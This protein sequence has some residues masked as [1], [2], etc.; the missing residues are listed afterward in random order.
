MVV[1]ASGVAGLM[2]CSDGGEPSNPA[3]TGGAVGSS[4]PETGGASGGST[5]SA[6]TSGMSSGGSSTGGTNPGAGAGGASAGN[7]G[8]GGM[9]VAGMNPGGMSGGSGGG[10]DAGGSNAG[11]SGG[12]AAGDTNGGGAAGTAGT[13]AGAGGTAGTAGDGG[14]G[15]MVGGAGSGGGEGGIAG[16]GANAG[17]EDID[18]K[19]ENFT[20]IADWEKVLGFRITNLLGHLD[21]ALAVAQS[22][23]GT[24][25]VGTV[26]QHLP[27][28]AM[29]KRR[30]GFSPETMD[31]EFFLLQLSPQGEVTIQERGTTE[32][33]T[34][35]GQTCA[36]CH[37]KAPEQFD[38]VCNTWGATG[39]GNCGFDFMEN[40]LNMQLASDPRCN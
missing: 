12:G 37:S 28:E 34:S 8:D 20:C 25:P 1:A 2:G 32:I 3:G 24:Y 9:S 22:G 13:D 16:G 40:F 26:I 10:G 11:M 17:D 23:T 14:M 5:A 4:N 33:K 38:F 36:S 29:V 7:A 19:P 21:E 39:S 6:G 31:W 27:T 15:G 35:M 30:K 18:M